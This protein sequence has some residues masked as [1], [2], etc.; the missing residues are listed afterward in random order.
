M[1][2]FLKSMLDMVKLQSVMFR[3]LNIQFSHYEPALM[4]DP[5]DHCEPNPTNTRTS[6]DS[7]YDP[8]VMG[9]SSF[10]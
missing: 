5:P 6:G 2:I 9:V 4:N 1:S 7:P 8:V 10:D 3:I